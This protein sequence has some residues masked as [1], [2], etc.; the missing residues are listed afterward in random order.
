MGSQ[1][2]GHSWVS[3]HKVPCIGQTHVFLP[4]SQSLCKVDV[5]NPWDEEDPKTQRPQRQWHGRDSNPV[6]SAECSFCSLWTGPKLCGSDFTDKG[7]QTRSLPETSKDL[8]AKENDM[9]WISGIHT[10]LRNLSRVRNNLS[11]F[12]LPEEPS[13]KINKSYS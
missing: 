11:D 10:W 6:L 8:A 4:P 5:T 13:L 7:G 3:E 9:G 1:R 12:F 2:I